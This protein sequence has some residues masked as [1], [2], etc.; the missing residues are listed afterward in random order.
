MDTRVRLTAAASFCLLPLVPLTVRLAK[1]QVMEH[2]ALE[3][4][5]SGEFSR[6]AEM[7]VP[8]ADIQDREGRVLAHSIPVW[9][10][11]ADRR[12]I[13]DFGA[14]AR[15]LSPLVGVPA[16]ELA[17]RYKAGGRFPWLALKLSFEQSQAVSKARIEGL[18]L[19]PRQ[20]RVYPNGA[21]ARSV[22][23]QVNSEGRGQS[24]VEL[25]L[26]ERLTGKPIKLKVIRDGSGRFIHRSV[27]Q[28]E[29]RPEPLKLTLDRNIQYF[30]EEALEEARKQYNVKS[31]IVAVSDPKT[32]EILA[33]A[34]WPESPLKN[35]IVQDTYEPGST[36]KIVAAAAALEER[37]IT[38][39]DVFF[40]ENG[41]YKLAPGVVIKDHEPKGDLTLSGILEHSSNIGFIKIVDRLGAERFHRYIRA[42]GFNAKTGITM[43]GETAGDVKPL[44]ATTRV[45]LAASSYG[46][47]VG[48]SALQML[49]AYSAVASRGLLYEPRIIDDGGEPRLVRRVA[50]EKTMERLTRLLEGVVERGT[51]T[52]AKIP[53]YRIAGKTGT[54][55]R[56][57]PATKK[58]SNTSYNASFAGFFPAQDPRWTVL[59]VMEDPKGGSYYGSQVAAPVFGKLA[60]RI[61][62][63]KGIPM[64]ANAIPK[65]LQD[66][67]LPR[68]AR[69][70]S[71][72]R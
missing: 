24:G 7:I 18:G 36:F 9:A 28:D 32:G 56:L 71:V 63:L 51:G 29:G 48:A 19:A 44:A 46:Y 30:A 26:N 59:V 37:A 6:N 66:G 65:G 67:P 38:E 42:F 23:G 31:G 34:V 41:A 21:L 57:D 25:S 43:P 10:V 27:E 22:L 45:A 3:T 15:K 49:L 50:S 61:L 70:A 64:E 53:G 55:R 33:M 35:P 60:R 1:L 16:K 8:R 17:R 11:F 47:G 20:E 13:K 14:V 69:L 62:T 39:Q 4:R 58:Y 2:R 52:P 40:C 72:A 12:M 5:A 54:S 68:T